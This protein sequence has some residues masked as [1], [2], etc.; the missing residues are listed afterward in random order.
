MM[1]LGMLSKTRIWKW[2][3]KYFQSSG[4]SEMFI[5][6]KLFTWVMY[7]QYWTW[8]WTRIWKYLK[9]I[10]STLRETGS[11]KVRNG[12]L[13]KPHPG[14]ALLFIWKKQF[15]NW[16]LI[17][18]HFKCFFYQFHPCSFLVSKNLDF[19]CNRT[20]FLNWDYYLKTCVL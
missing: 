1:K 17:N 14:D 10:S 9:K 20:G 19:T 15:F 8:Y 7:W 6:L 18:R 5:F 11:D 3:E 4:I 12:F 16:F 2:E 13:F